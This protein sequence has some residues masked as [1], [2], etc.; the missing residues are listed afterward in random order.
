MFLMLNVLVSHFNLQILNPGSELSGLNFVRSSGLVVLRKRFVESLLESID[1]F[2][3]FAHS[4]HVGSQ[5]MLVKVAHS[6]DIILKELSHFYFEHFSLLFLL[7]LQCLDAILEIFIL[8]LKSA[9][10]NSVT[11][12]N[13]CILFVKVSQLLLFT[14]N[15]LF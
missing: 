12:L 15:Q 7:E 6:P 4:I 11:V 1:D 5:L 13:P 3:I 2:L 14:L 9:H 10:L 8:L